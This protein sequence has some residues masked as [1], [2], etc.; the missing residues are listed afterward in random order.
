VAIEDGTHGVADGFVE[1]VA[2]DEY[3]EE[4][5]DEPF[6]KFPARSKIFRQQMKTLG[7]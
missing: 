4:P 1:I 7:G 6:G 3:G 5:G 2:F